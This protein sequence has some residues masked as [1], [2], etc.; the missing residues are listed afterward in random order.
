MQHLRWA[1]KEAIDLLVFPEAYLLG[2]SYE[3]E[4]IRS[5]AEQAS[6]ALA[7]LC[8]QV[9]AF[10]VTLVVGAFDVAPPHIYSSAFVI[11]RGRISGRFAKAYPNEP[12]VAA[13]REFPRS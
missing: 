13:G 7:D 8:Q 1:T 5:R 11:E 4:V 6:G 3:P 9:A 12:G 2:H 10:P